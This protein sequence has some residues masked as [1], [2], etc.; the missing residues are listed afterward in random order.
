MRKDVMMQRNRI[1]QLI[2]MSN[3]FGSHRNCCKIIMG[4]SYEHELAKFNR[5]FK[6][7]ND[8]KEILTECVFETGGKA[9]ILVLD[10]GL[11]VECLVSEKKE[12]CM[13]KIQK[14]PP[15]LMVEY[16]EVR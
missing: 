12:E 14:Y 4:N 11:V 5:C 13:N 10:D 8:G 2:R 7:I 3:R 6:E 16:I 15:C 9:D 1:S